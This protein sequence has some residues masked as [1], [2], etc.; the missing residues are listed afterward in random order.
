MVISYS[1][2]G[3][4]S[5]GPPCSACDHRFEMGRQ[6]A[7]RPAN[8]AK[9]M[10][11]PRPVSE[12]VP[13]AVEQAWYGPRRAGGGRLVIAKCRQACIGQ[14]RP[15]SFIVTGDFISSPCSP[16][17][18]GWRLDGPAGTVHAIAD[19]FSCRTLPRKHVEQPP[20]AGQPV[21]S[22]PGVDHAGVMKS[23]V[24]RTEAFSTPF[25]VLGLLREMVPLPSTGRA[26][27]KRKAARRPNFSFRPGQDSDCQVVITRQIRKKGIC[28]RYRS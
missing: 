18:Y 11:A 13:L 19:V 20:Q 3:M 14:N 12:I 24:Q 6:N 22:A 15:E 1:P 9:V 17:P 4:P 16:P 5:K 10:C 7:L 28:S 25:R 26:R 8:V 2:T 27:Y 21:V 23:R